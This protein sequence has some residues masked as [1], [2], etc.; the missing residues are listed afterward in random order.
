MSSAMDLLVERAEKSHTFRLNKAANTPLELLELC[1]QDVPNSWTCGNLQCPI[2][3]NGHKKPMGCAMGLIGMWSGLGYYQTWEIQD[4]YSA[5][6]YHGRVGSSVIEWIFPEDEHEVVSQSNIA[7]KATMYLARAIPTL[8]IYD[9]YCWDE[10]DHTAS[11]TKQAQ[12]WLDGLTTA[13][14][15]RAI[16][17]YNDSLEGKTAKRRAAKWFDRAIKLAREDQAA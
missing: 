16:V 12:A 10:G 1:R 11:K 2:A 4:E 17:Y 5:E 9:Q 6:Q 14:A 8:V 15:V 3:L 7:S 13:D